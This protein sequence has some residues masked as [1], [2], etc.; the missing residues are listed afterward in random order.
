MINCENKDLLCQIIS[1]NI[2]FYSNQKKSG[3]K[4]KQH[5]GTIP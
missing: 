5:D 4:L 2:Y 3:L 1:I